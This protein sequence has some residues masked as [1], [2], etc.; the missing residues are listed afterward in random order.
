[1]S[2]F[3]V[4]KLSIIVQKFSKC[5]KNGNDRLRKGKLPRLLATGKRSWCTV[6][7]HFFRKMGGLDF[8]LRCNYNAKY[9]DQLPVFYKNILDS[10]NEWKTFYG[11]DQ[12]QDIVLFNNKEILVDGKP[13]YI[14]ECFKKGVVSIKDLLKNDGNFLTFKAF[15]VK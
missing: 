1:M 3:L 2:F 10:F 14:N 13:V 12:S 7:N 8:I 15:S 5:L 9:F 6:P 4:E 11:Y